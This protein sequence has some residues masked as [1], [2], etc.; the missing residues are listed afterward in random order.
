MQIV[1][2][3]V[4]VPA[5]SNISQHSI[6]TLAHQLK[7]IYMSMQPQTTNHNNYLAYNLTPLVIE[8]LSFAASRHSLNLDFFPF[9]TWLTANG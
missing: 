1:A 7:V 4:V 2:S 5:P 3:K 8:A 9:S 6:N